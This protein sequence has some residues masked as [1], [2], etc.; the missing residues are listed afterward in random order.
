VEVPVNT[1]LSIAMLNR[2]FIQASALLPQQ[3]ADEPKI[4]FSMP[5]HAA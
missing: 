4:Y 3:T 2:E 1:P 5:F